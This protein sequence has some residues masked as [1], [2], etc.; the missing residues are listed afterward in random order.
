MHVHLDFETIWEVVALIAGVV[1]FYRFIVPR[2]FPSVAGR[3]AVQING[4]EEEVA[5]MVQQRT[6]P[7]LFNAQSMGRG[8]AYKRRSATKGVQSESSTNA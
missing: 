2:L 3:K 5:F 6:A 7:S 8:D 1:I 4:V